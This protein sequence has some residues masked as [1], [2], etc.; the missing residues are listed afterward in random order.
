MPWF[1]LGRLLTITIITFI[2]LVLILKI[3]SDL[4]KRMDLTNVTKVM[5]FNCTRMVC[6]PYRNVRWPGIADSIIEEIFT[7]NN[8]YISY[9]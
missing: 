1:F 9:N 6:A 8:F 4:K 2:F 5:I 7:F 3:C